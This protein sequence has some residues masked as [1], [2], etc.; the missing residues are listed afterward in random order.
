MKS[1]LFF[2][3][4]VNFRNLYNETPN[5]FVSADHSSK[6]KNISPVHNAITAWIE[7]G[8]LVYSCVCGP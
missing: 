5:V 1:F 6:G 4:D 7:V 3:K 8:S 2:F